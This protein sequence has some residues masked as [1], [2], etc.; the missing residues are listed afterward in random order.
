MSNLAENPLHQL[1]EAMVEAV[2]KAG[3]ATVLVS[4]RHR[5]P[6]S[7][8]AYAAD[9]ILTADHVIERE[10]DIRVVLPDGSEHA[11]QLLGRDA[12]SDLALLRLAGQMAAQVAIAHPPIRVG[13][14]VLALNIS[15]HT[16][17]FH[18]SSIYA[19][20]GATNRAEAIRQGV[21]KGLIVF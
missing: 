21:R 18:I 13:Q 11:A 9:L 20:L 16:V 2:D 19:K 3:A 14:L 5:F 10:E 6:A 4:A 15:E 1:S 12:A 17:K 7:G 8:I